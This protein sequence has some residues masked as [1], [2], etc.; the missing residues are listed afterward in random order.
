MSS[1]KKISIIGAGQSGAFAANEIRKHDKESTITIFSDENYLPYERPP[2]SK[3][4]II[5]KKKYEDLSFFS[6]DFYNSENIQIENKAVAKVDFKTKSILTIDSKTQTYDSLLITTGSKNKK[7]N[8]GN[9]NEDLNNNILYLRDIED[10][11]K[12]KKAIDSF[13]SFVIIGGGFIGLEIAS[14]IARLGK[15]VNVIEMGSQLMSRIIPKKIASIVLDY[16]KKNGNSIFLNSNIISARKLNTGYKIELH[17]N[18]IIEADFIIAGIGSFANVDLF[19]NTSLK[20]ENGILTDEYCRTSERDVFAAGDVANFFHPIY[21]KQI[22]LESYQHA[23]NHGIVAAKNILGHKIPYKKIPWMWSDQFDL[24]LQL[25]GVCDDFDQEIQ[26][27]NNVKEGIINF[28]LKN[29][30][31]MGACG[32]GL[33]GKVGRDIRLAGKIAESNIEVEMEELQNIEFKLNKLLK[34]NS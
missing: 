33:A 9:D 1:T 15:V 27:G 14:S 24:N 34:N 25:V 19:E 7:L 26:R 4:S 29:K 22:R 10:S 23:Q 2:L 17:N 8:F 31:I 21:D 18:N 30:K 3:D 20:L 6:N 13:N 32:I 11:K 28:F 16:H 5:G 12:I